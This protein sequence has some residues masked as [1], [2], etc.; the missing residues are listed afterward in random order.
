[1]QT[2]STF[3]NAGGDFVGE[4]KNGTSMKKEADADQLISNFVIS[5][6]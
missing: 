6:P 2:S 4:T 5:I 3:L 1:M